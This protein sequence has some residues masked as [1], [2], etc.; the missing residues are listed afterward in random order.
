MSHYK[1]KH[2]IEINDNENVIKFSRISE[3]SECQHNR[4]TICNEESEIVCKDCNAKLNPVH[5][6]SRHLKKLNEASKRNNAVLS[7]YREIW[8]KL[9]SKKNFM[10]KKCHEVNDIDF[11]KLPHKSAVQRGISVVENDYSGM[12]VEVVR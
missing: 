6:I 4:V 5:W 1:E 12:V 8:H 2:T 9:D 3:K 10:C 11:R 7:E